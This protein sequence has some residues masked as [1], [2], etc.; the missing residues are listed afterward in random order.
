MKTVTINA[1]QLGFAINE[2]IRT[3]YNADLAE[4]VRIFG[5]DDADHLFSKYRHDFGS[6]E[7]EF[8]CSLDSAN[9]QKLAETVMPRESKS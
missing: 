8:I 1:K 4:F 3:L 6:R 9:L 5:E 7:G 2:A